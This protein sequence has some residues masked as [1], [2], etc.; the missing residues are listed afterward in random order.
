MY[1]CTQ[2]RLHGSA[3]KLD[4]PHSRVGIPPLT[5]P[6]ATTCTGYPRERTCAATVLGAG[7]LSFGYFFVIVYIFS[8]I[9]FHPPTTT[10][11]QCET[12]VINRVRS[13]ASTRVRCTRSTRRRTAVGVRAHCA[14]K[15]LYGGY[16]H[17]TAQIL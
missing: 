17:D 12:L 9:I 2:V 6:T 13:H 14:R 15:Y 7:P 1:R 3:V 11:T 8:P 5:V 16:Q 4:G 10:A